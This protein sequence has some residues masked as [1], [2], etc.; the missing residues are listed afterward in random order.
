MID[1]TDQPT[2]IEHR[3]TQPDYNKLN[4]TTT[5]TTMSTITELDKS[6]MCV[7][8]RFS[9]PTNYLLRYRLIQPF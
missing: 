9:F 3:L 4:K 5:T 6:Y 8:L 2:T 1:T 7:D